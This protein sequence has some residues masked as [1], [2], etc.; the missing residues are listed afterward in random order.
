[1][2]KLKEVAEILGVSDR[3]VERYLKSYFSLEKGTYQ[4][5]EKMLEVLKSEY[6]ESEYDSIV[7]EFTKDEYQEFQK[8][9]SEYPLLKERIEYILND[10]EYYR[11][12]MSSKEKQMEVLLNMMEQRNFIEAKEKKLDK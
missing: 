10:M 1:M 3:S 11:N 9:L 12:S 7:E 4:V 2:Y 5:S 8:R 6:L